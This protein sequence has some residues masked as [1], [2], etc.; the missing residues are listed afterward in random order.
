MQS[1]G[2]FAGIDA[3]ISGL[4]NQIEAGK[5]KFGPIKNLASRAKN[6]VGA[7]DE[8][9]KNFASFQSK[10]ENMRNGVL[11]LN[12][13]VQT[14]G[15]AQRAMGEIMSNPND[16]DVVKQRLAEIRALNRRAVE[17]RKNNVNTLR[18]NFGHDELDFSKYEKQPATT[19]LAPQG[20]QPYS[21]AE[22]EARYQAWKKSQ[23][24]K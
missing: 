1:I 12:K 7:S 15:D 5:L 23:V 10:L 16:V 4:E 13:G 14:E 22:K 21:D 6:Y 11:L 24:A 9:S 3:D 20:A 19:N 2:T 8:E 18:S 17:L